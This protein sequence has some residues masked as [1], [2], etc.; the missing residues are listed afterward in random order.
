MILTL[1]VL[2]QALDNIGPDREPHRIPVPPPARYTARREWA[3]KAGPSARD[4]PIAP[5][6][7]HGR[8]KECAGL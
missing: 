2:K 6:A 4:Y 7:V 5:E 1:C 8:S 3:A